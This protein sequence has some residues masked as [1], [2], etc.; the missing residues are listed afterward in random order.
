MRLL[1][2]MGRAEELWLGVGDHQQ[3]GGGADQA[4][5][6]AWLSCHLSVLLVRQ[7]AG[8]LRPDFLFTQQR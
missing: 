2:C 8:L 3:S 1:V 5:A 4:A 6:A 7:L